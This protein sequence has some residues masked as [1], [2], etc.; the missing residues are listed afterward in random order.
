M[1]TP[2]RK[3]LHVQDMAKRAIA[4]GVGQAPS[5]ESNSDEAL[6]RAIAVVDAVSEIEFLATV[7]HG[8]ETFVSLLVD[9]RIREILEQTMNS[10][11]A[12]GFVTYDKHR[13]SEKMGDLQRI[14]GVEYQLPAKTEDE[15]PTVI[16]VVLTVI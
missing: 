13:G 14:I 16:D 9:N 6:R 3:L 7:S 1:R 10:T 11:A 2:G 12:W 4:D 5:I 8:A 15:P